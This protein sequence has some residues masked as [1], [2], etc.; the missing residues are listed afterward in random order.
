M[1]YR[2]GQKKKKLT[3]HNLVTGSVIAFAFIGFSL[4]VLASQRQTNT[5][6]EASQQGFGCAKDPTLYLKDSKDF[7][8]SVVYTIN[9]KNND[10]DSKETKKEKCKTDSYEIS[11]DAPRGWDASIYGEDL[12]ERKVVI[13]V[14]EGQTGIFK[15]KVTR[16]K[17]ATNG[18]YDIK[19]RA[20]NNRAGSNAANSITLPYKV[21]G[22]SGGS[23]GSSGG[24]D[25]NGGSGNSDKSE[26]SNKPC[27]KEPTLEVLE[28]TQGRVVKNAYNVKLKITNNCKETHSFSLTYR[29]NSTY[30]IGGFT[31]DHPWNGLV[32]GSRI[33]DILVYL[34]NDQNWT[35]FTLTAKMV[36]PETNSQHSIY[37]VVP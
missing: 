12:S 10:R 36:L 6:S 8:E 32:N 19:V 14:E 21:T 4:T 25:R 26:D 3:L 31:Q 5:K 35:A 29:G 13:G 33:I 18:S 17:S 34:K 22:S 37:V 24:S 30:K 20:V 23:G 15:A 2:R 27:S 11:V 1:I 16:P 28:K 7:E 9:I